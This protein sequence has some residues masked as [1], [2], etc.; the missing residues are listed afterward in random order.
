MTNITVLTGT[1][2]N[3][4]WLF[5]LLLYIKQQT[6]NWHLCLLTPVRYGCFE[7]CQI[8]TTFR[9]FLVLT[10]EQINIFCERQISIKLFYLYQRLQCRDKYFFKIKIVFFFYLRLSASSKENDLPLCIYFWYRTDS[11]VPNT[12]IYSDK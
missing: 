12:S 11:G 6:V 5:S 4:T 9:L 7:S 8:P 3:V 2:W 1:N 10:S